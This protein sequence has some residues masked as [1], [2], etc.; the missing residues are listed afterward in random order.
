MRTLSFIILL[1]TFGILTTQAQQG[2]VLKV[3]M[4]ASNVSS[5]DVGETS[6]KF[7]FT[8]GVGYNFQLNDNFAIE[9]ALKYAMKGY[10]KNDQNLNLGYLALPLTLKVYPSES[11]VIHAGPEVGFLMSDKLQ[12]ADLGDG[13]FESTDFG[14]NF[15]L[16]FFVNEALSVGFN[17]VIGFSDIYADAG[18]K[19]KNQAWLTSFNYY[20]LK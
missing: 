13:E 1:M 5:D 2:V 16:D 17:G 3:E 19:G 10:S 11:I 6:Y 9:P 12:G 20:F 4:G 18:K 15:G 7:S 14:A 8:P